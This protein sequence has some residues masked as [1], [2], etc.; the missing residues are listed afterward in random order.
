MIVLR[1]YIASN[2]LFDAFTLLFVLLGSYTI[3]FN[4]TINDSFYYL[5]FGSLP[6]FFVKYF[7][8]IRKIQTINK[9]INLTPSISP[10]L[11]LDSN[12]Y[13]FFKVILKKD[14]VKVIIR[15]GLYKP[16]IIHLN[17]IDKNNSRIVVLKNEWY[18]WN[19]KYMGWN[20]YYQIILLTNEK[21]QE[22]LRFKSMEWDGKFNDFPFEEFRKLGE[23][24]AFLSNLNV[25]Y[26]EY[27]REMD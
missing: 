23:N 19:I 15:E 1:N 7:F 10:K 5:Y 16:L 6:L 14:N 13:K 25:A 12:F 21:Q 27:N 18:N 2:F 9:L 11:N 4:E 3:I 20:S 22:I 8:S 17:T 26:I 24:I